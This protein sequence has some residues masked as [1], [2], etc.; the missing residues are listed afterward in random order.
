MKVKA[1]TKEDKKYV[2]AYDVEKSR[3]I[4]RDMRDDESTPADYL[5]TAA[6]CLQGVYHAEVVNAA[7][8]VACNRRVWDAYSVGSGDLDVYVEGLAKVEYF[9]G[10]RYGVAYVEMGAYLSDI[11]Q[12]TGSDVDDATTTSMFY[13]TWYKMNQ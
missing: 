11:W 9:D 2:T 13:L 8:R 5:L 6:N 12:L 4:I 10:S 3:D 1:F 7:A